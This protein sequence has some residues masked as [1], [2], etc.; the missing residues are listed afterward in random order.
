MNH[1]SNFHDTDRIQHQRR[2]SHPSSSSSTNTAYAVLISIIIYYAFQYF[3]V[4]S[5]VSLSLS[6]VLWNALVW[7]TPSPLIAKLDSGFR[8]V[9]FEERDVSYSAYNSKMH[10]SKSNALRRVLGLDG[11]GI[12]TTLQRTRT[13]SNLGSILKTKPND[14]PPGLGNWNNSCYQNSV[15]QS[16]AALKS[17]PAF[18]DE[19]VQHYGG[20]STKSALK[21]LIKRLND[22]ANIGNI[23][24]TPAELKNMSSWQ[25]QDAQEYFSKLSDEMENDI[26]EFS[27][28]QNQH[29][30]LAELPLESKGQKDTHVAEDNSTITASR[31]FVPG[32]SSRLGQLPED[33]LSLMMR[34]PFEGLLAQ[35]VGCTSCGF[36]E[37]L[38]LVP[39]NCLTVSLGRDWMYDIRSCLEEYTALE[40]ING[41]ECGKC[42]LLRAQRSLEQVL[43]S[44]ENR[45][46][47]ENRTVI[48]SSPS[49]KGPFEERLRLVRKALENDDFSDLVLK[50]C[51]IPQKNRFLTT[52]SRQAVIARTPNCLVIHVNRSTFDE[53]TGV[54]S[55][56]LAHVRFPQQLDLAPWCLGSTSGQDR[57]DPEVEKWNSN[58]SESMLA[59]A[60]AGEFGVDRNYELRAVIT[61][62]G[63][64]ENG[65]YVCLKKTS[66]SS[67]IDE[68]T[69]NEGEES[70]WRL[71]DEDVSEVDEEIVLSQGGVFMLFYEQMA[72]S[73]HPEHQQG[74]LHRMTTGDLDETSKIKQTESMPVTEV[75]PSS[76]AVHQDEPEVSVLPIKSGLPSPPSTPA[77]YHPEI[78]TSSLETGLQPSQAPDM[79]SHTSDIPSKAPESPSSLSPPKSTPSDPLVPPASPLLSDY[80][81]TAASLQQPLREKVPLSPTS[82][83]TASPRSGRGRG[84]GMDSVAGF[85]QA[86]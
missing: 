78:E 40:P 57:E 17:L 21:D 53:T 81:D 35:R 31:S 64:H 33:L 2:S 75:A 32:T 52:K 55:K 7:I 18:L 10:A 29:N 15:L 70:W 25:Q 47:A 14:C 28:R 1:G 8:T 13:V 77:Q 22:P 60:E 45:A 37:G 26:S 48:E 56:N 80:N 73:V 82:M 76:E 4:T 9:M 63:R 3:N 50:Q 61:H 12:L 51:Q 30:G 83:R 71:S 79:S 85:V 86:N 84:R 16:L 34:N 74:P 43:R 67:S 5:F 41:V 23:I 20:T 24:W 49:Q 62:Y 19:D 72:P 39:F 68:K 36:V 46:E 44:I 65:H 58:P 59:D 42:T 38:S 27:K 6:E 69:A 11:A 66:C 54:Q